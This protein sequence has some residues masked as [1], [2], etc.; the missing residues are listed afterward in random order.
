V[1]NHWSVLALVALVAPL[2]A[3]CSNGGHDGLVPG[4]VPD[5]VSGSE[6]WVQLPTGRV[7]VTVGDP[8]RTIPGGEVVGRKAIEAGDGREFLPVGVSYDDIVG[9][10]FDAPQDATDPDELTRLDLHVGDK[11]YRVPFDSVGTLSYLEVPT[12]GDDALSL[13]VAFDGVS[14]SVDSAGKRETGDAA[15]G[16][17]DA[18]TRAELLSCGE[19][20]TDQAARTCRYNLWEYP[21]VE[22]LGWAS[23]R[24]SGTTWVVVTAQTWLRAD[25]LPV[26][27]KTCRA[28]AMGGSIRVRVDGEA[29]TA[30][31]PVDANNRAGGHGL[32]AKVAFL[33]PHADQHELEVTSTWG[34]RLGDRSADREFVDRV[35]ASS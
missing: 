9:V 19:G 26:D 28:V 22:G 32:G 31:L 1:R 35:S 30:E 2:A 18:S 29:G 10:P 16:L 20:A 8:V 25:Q 11:A 6:M 4:A 15:A 33:V 13:D 14:Q 17:Y 23:K 12:A 3:A 7:T 21:Y 24:T 27:G 34:C 5:S